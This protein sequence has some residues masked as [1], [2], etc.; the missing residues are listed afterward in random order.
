MYIHIYIYKSIKLFASCTAALAGAP[1]LA[2]W[3]F[4]LLWCSPD[5]R[6]SSKAIAFPPL[7]C[8]VPNTIKRNN[9]LGE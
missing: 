7:G 2:L 4:D 3:L 5:S 9:P 8:I 6:A 1:N